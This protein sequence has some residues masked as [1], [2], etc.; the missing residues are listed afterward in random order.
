VGNKDNYGDSNGGGTSNNQLKAIRGSKR[1][2][3]GGGSGDGGDGNVNSNSNQ[4]GD[5]DSNN[6]NP[7]ALCIPPK[8]FFTPPSALAE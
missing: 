1:N 5:G 6:A 4:D 2:G 7:D 3:G 8:A